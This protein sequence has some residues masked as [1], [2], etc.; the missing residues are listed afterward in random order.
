KSHATMAAGTEGMCH[1]FGN[2]D[3][4]IAFYRQPN[5][6]DFAHVLVHETTHGFLHRY[7]S[8]VSIPSWANEG[9]AET[10]AYQM[11]Q[12]KGLAQSAVA[13]AKNDLMNRKSLDKF[14]DADH[15][16]AWQYPVARTFT[17]FMI[18]QSKNGYV[19]FINGLKDGMKLDDAMKQK[20]GVT[21]EQLVDAY[22]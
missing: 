8:P 14:F 17:E 16:V 18:L 2:G 20:Y 6:L 1:E 21:V 19:E 7:R 4:H 11:V 10:I 13:D 12:Q 15:I 3:V 22:G 5:D 9:L